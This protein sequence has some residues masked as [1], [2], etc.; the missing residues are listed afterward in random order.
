MSN[1]IEIVSG[2]EGWRLAS[3]L[4][5][6]VWPPEVVAT[7]PWKDVVWAPADSRVLKMHCHNEVIGHA[8]IYLR[9]A[10]FDARPVKIGG[11][12][13][14]AGRTNESAP[15]AGALPIFTRSEPQAATLPGMTSSSLLEFAIGIDRGFIASG[16]SRTRSTCRSPF[17]RL[18]PLTLT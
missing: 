17:F 12:G 2:D 16:I 18:A 3:P 5:K 8:G 6:A 10:E 11:V 15:K 9:D 13:D 4:L 14:Y 7:L 1:R